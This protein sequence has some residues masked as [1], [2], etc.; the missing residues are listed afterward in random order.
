MGVEV[1]ENGQAKRIFSHLI[2]I[3]FPDPA[4]HCEHHAAP[5][6]S[7]RFWIPQ[8]ACPRVFSNLQKEQLRSSESCHRCQ[9]RWM[10]IQGGLL[11]KII[12]VKS[13]CAFPRCLRGFSHCTW[14]SGSVGSNSV[15]R[16]QPLQP[17]LPDH[18][19]NLFLLLVADLTGRGGEVQHYVFY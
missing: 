7:L 10:L 6:T 9:K 8:C 1:Y 11:T 4:R 15:D 17:Y 16:R 3:L 2:D 5:L 13:F 18:G 12:Q 19:A 14:N